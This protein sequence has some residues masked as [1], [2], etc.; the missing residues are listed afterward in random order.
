M[1]YLRAGMCFDWLKK[2][3][4]GS[5]Y[6]ARANE[7]DPNFYYVMTNQG[8]HRMNVAFEAYNKGDFAKALQYFKEARCY[9]DRSQYF[10]LNDIARVYLPIVD[11]KI[12]ELSKGK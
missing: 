5:Y 3:D 10:V 7:L 6:F 9:L 12:A 8:W 4:Q 11:E 1:S 2:A